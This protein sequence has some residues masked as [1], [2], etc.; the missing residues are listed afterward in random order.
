[1]RQG[2]AA[3]PRD[4]ALNMA[5]SRR[6]FLRAAGATAGMLSLGGL[7]A[8]CSNEEDTEGGVVH[9][10]NWALYLDRDHNAAGQLIRPSL[11]QFTNDT[12]I[13]VDYREVIADAEAF[14]QQIAPYLASGRATGWDVMVITNGVTMTK[15]L[16]LDYLVPLDTTARPNFDAHASDK[17]FDPPYDPQA[18]FSMPWQS[19]M[20][21]IAYNPALTGRPITSLQELFSP[22]WAGKIGMFGDAVDLPNLTMIALGIDPTT[23][24]PDD[25]AKAAD[26]LAKQRADGIVNRSFR[27]N[28]VQALTNGDVAISMAWSGDIFQANNIGAQEG[29][30]FV[31]PD[32]GGILWT[33]AMVIP[34]LASHPIDAM[35]LMDYVFKPE[36]AA[37]IAEY[38]NYVTPVPDAKTI[39]EDDAEHAQSQEEKDALEA[40]VS[41]PLVFPTEDDLSALKTYRELTTDDEI[42]LWNDTFSPYYA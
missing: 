3:D 26:A 11:L 15:L 4:L 41:S 36:I 33:D 9:M 8:A 22:E 42:A 6:G 25:W 19:G 40:I 21:G 13:Q 10:A 14:Y 35:K 12:G 31:I 39:I 37:L 1:M 7:L 18:R 28:Y 5:L 16:K 2:M 30:Q 32:E 29:L 34:K 38:V 20:T 24:T 17:F 23:S 27:Q